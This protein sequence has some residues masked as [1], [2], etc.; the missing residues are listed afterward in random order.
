MIKI[1]GKEDEFGKFKISISNGQIFT[2]NKTYNSSGEYLWFHTVDV[3]SRDRVKY[4]NFQ[5]G[6]HLNTFK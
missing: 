3:E 1:Y 4:I 2:P 6:I 5:N